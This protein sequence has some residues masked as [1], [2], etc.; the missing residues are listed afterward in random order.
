MKT[1][2]S[3]SVLALVLAIA[4]SLQSCGEPPVINA[5]EPQ[6]DPYKENMINA[7]KT[8]NSAEQTQIENYIARRGWQM[9][10]LD[11]GSWI[12]ET[13]QGK[14]AKVDW[15]DTLTVR[16]RLEALNG[17]VIYHQQE[18]TFVVGQNKP[19]VGLDRGVMELRRGSEA[20]LIVPSSLGYGV[21]GD[22]DRVP[23]RTVLVYILTIT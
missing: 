21:V 18:E 19:T 12:E 23:A 4:F 6:G 14:G 8:I 3:A 10:Q 15:E 22:G 2:A 7:N 13:V 20:R 17:A 16:Y 5:P 1:K 9:R 11:N